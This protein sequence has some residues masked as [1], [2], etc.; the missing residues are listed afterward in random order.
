MG[1]AGRSTVAKHTL[2]AAHRPSMVLASLLPAQGKS[3]KTAFKSQTNIFISHHVSVLQR[4][5]QLSFSHWAIYTVVKWQPVKQIVDLKLC[6]AI[7]HWSFPFPIPITFCSLGSSSSP[8]LL[9]AGRLTGHCV[10][11]CCYSH[12]HGCQLSCLWGFGHT[13]CLFSCLYFGTGL[14]AAPQV[15]QH[16]QTVWFLPFLLTHPILLQREKTLS[17]QGERVIS[18]KLCMGIRTDGTGWLGT[19]RVKIC[20]QQ[21]PGW[22]A[23]H[24]PWAFCKTTA[25]GFY[26]NLHS[27]TFSISRTWK[28]FIVIKRN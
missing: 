3:A 22:S 12:V 9:S 8:M 25:L 11:A 7:R 1:T 14:L 21:V 10:L 27:Y 18:V 15:K 13:S 2:P 16:K 17:S 5:C 28:L 23:F 20:T 6:I 26:L 24:L 4:F 19:S